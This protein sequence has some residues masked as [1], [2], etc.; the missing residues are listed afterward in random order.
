MLEDAIPIEVSKGKLRSSREVFKVDPLA[1]REK[2]ELTKEEKRKERTAKKRKVKAAFKAKATQKKEQLREQGLALAQ[3]FAVRET[4]R[5]MEKISK[6]NKGKGKS[7]DDGEGLGRRTN[8][9]AKVFAN[10]EKI[11]AADYK[12][13]DDKREARES[14]K[15]FSSVATHGQASKRFKL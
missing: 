1:L 4:Q 5:Q 10:L 2:T 3:K 9:S 8:S 14:G 11:V 7:K 6:K 15:K 12:K 13:R